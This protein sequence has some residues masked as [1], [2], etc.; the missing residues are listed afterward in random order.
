MERA[1]EGWRTAS[2]VL[3]QA[4]GSSRDAGLEAEDNGDEVTILSD[5]SH[6]HM[7]WPP[8][9]NQEVEAVWLDP[10]AMISAIVAEEMVAVSGWTDGMLKV[11]TLA[12]AGRV[13]GPLKVPRL[14][15]IRVRSWLGTF[16][17]DE[18]VQPGGTWPGER[19][20]FSHTA[21]AG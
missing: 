2:L 17:Q 14:Q 8:F 4:A 1:G 6:I 15:C 16:D 11:A 5:H 12:E 19:L 9:V 3:P 21:P 7:T 13:S 10:M 18:D 20:R